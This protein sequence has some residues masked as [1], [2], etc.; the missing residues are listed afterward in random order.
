MKSLKQILKEQEQLNLNNT[1]KG[2]IATISV[3]ATPSLA[4][5]NILGARNAMASADILQSMGYI[6]INHDTNEAELTPRG[7][8]VLRQENIKD[9]AG[10]LTERGEELVNWYNQSITGWQVFESFKYFV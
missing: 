8:D 1:Q 2:M 7:E 5:G 6:R 4:Y 3:S 9:E 10:E